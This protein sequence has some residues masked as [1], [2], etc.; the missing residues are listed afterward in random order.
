[1]SGCNSGKQAGTGG[2]GSGAGS[3]AG[4]VSSGVMKAAAVRA[5]K[6]ALVR[7]MEQPGQIVP[8]ETT[9]L[10][11]KVAGYVKEVKKDIG[12]VVKPGETLAVIAR[13]SCSKRSS[14]KRRR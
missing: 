12:D 14:K 3:G 6:K 10:M 5:E 11:A 9:P 7:T 13:R 2:G 1:L 4:G 8:L